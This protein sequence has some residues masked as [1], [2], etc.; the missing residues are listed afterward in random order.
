MASTLWMKRVLNFRMTNMHPSDVSNLLQSTTKHHTTHV[1]IVRKT[2]FLFS[3]TKGYSR[4]IIED[5][6]FLV[7]FG[8]GIR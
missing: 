4:N 7:F 6:K 1:P 8:K 5:K 2:D 3:K